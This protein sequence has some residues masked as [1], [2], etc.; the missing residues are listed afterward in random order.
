MVET[1]VLL[2]EPVQVIEERGVWSRVRTPW[3][4]S[5]KGAGGYPGWVASGSLA[6]PAPTGS[7]YAVVVTRR[8]ELAGVPAGAPA[9]CAPWA[10]VLP[11]LEILPG[12]VR[13]GLP[14]GGD[15]SISMATCLIRDAPHLGSSLLDAAELIR[16]ASTMLGVRHVLGGMTEA[17]VDCSGLVHL[18]CRIL[19]RTVPRDAK[20]LIGAG[21]LIPIADASEGDLLFFQRPGRPVH[22]VGIAVDRP[23][24]MLNSPGGGV[25]KIEPL[26]PDRR[27]TLTATATS[28]VSRTLHST[29]TWSKG[30][31]A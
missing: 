25:A 15:A 31:L 1:Q 12:T 18:A 16:T 2:G 19:G 22:H 29:A 23:G 10:A 21:H 8:S 20:D 7:H 13:V 27:R 24:A 6:T 3:Q 14:G 4:P 30:V 5:R 28:V 9:C 17:G 26:S 11:V